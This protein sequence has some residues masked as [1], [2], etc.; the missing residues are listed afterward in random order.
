MAK[1]L[2]QKEVS[3]SQQHIAEYAQSMVNKKTTNAQ[4]FEVVRSLYGSALDEN[5]VISN[6]GEVY[7][8]CIET[9]N[10]ERAA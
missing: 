4:I 8:Y 5:T 9:R 10:K 3:I 2:K 7:W 1:I 6:I